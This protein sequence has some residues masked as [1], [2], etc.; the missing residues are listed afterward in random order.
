IAV[1][2]R[3]LSPNGESRSGVYTASFQPAQ[4]IPVAFQVAGYVESIKQVLG[5]DGHQRSLQGGDWVKGREQLASVRSDLYLAQVNQAN[6]ALGGAKAELVRAKN[7]L[8]RDSQLVSQ[9]VIAQAM[10]DV[11]Q[12]RFQTAESAVKQQEAALRQAQIN[13]DYCRLTSPIDGMVI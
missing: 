7:D 2:V 11:S 13:L 4:Q 6:S 1:T 12:Q 3:T 9:H 8:D 10:Y 5:A